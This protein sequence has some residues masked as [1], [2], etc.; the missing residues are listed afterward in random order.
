M[1]REIMTRVVMKMINDNHNDDDHVI[2]NESDSFGSGK[3]TA[4]TG[5]GYSVNGI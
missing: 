3:K 4:P 1:M 5:E 2:D